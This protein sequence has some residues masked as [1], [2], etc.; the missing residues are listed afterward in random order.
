MHII[1]E[2]KINVVILT[3]MLYE[4]NIFSIKFR[5]GFSLHILTNILFN[6][7]QMG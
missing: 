1:F 7:Y 4:Y 3:Y 2:K 5:F 6:L